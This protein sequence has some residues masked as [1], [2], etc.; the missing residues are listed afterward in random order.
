MSA[1]I[2]KS[3]ITTNLEVSRYNEEN[4][5]VETVTTKIM[6]LRTPTQKR[7]E[8]FLK[9]DKGYLGFK[10][11]STTTDVYVM[12]AEEFINNAVKKER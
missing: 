4:A 6:T 1:T 5:E 3:V 7:I 9:N 10:V 2:S 12:D 8:S 11:L